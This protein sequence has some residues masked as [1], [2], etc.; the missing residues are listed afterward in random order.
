[1]KLGIVLTIKPYVGGAFT[2]AAFMLEAISRKNDKIHEVVAY[3]SDDLWKKYLTRYDTITGIR[4][5]GEYFEIIDELNHSGCDIIL[6][7]CQLH[8]CRDISIPTITPI[9]DLMHIYERGKGFTELEED[10]CYNIRQLHF[11]DIYSY[12]AGILTDSELGRKHV[13][14]Q[15]G[16]VKEDR[17]YVLPFSVP[18][19]LNEQYGS[20]VAPVVGKYIF[21]PA[22]FWKEK[23][24]EALIKAA[25]LL[26]QK[27]IVVKMVFVGSDKGYLSSLKQLMIDEGVSDE[28]EILG[29]VPDNEMYMLYK[30]A[31]AMVMPSFG[32]PTNL[33]PL[34]AMYVGCPV[35]V[36]NNYAMPE[37]IGDAGLSFDPYDINELANV[38]E[39][40][41]CDDALCRELSTKG[42]KQIK[43]FSIDCFSSNLMNCI[44]DVYHKE[45]LLW[46][47]IKDFVKKC[48]EEEKVYI[49]G[50]GE[51]A[52]YILAILKHYG[53]DVEG[54]IVSGEPTCERFMGKPVVSI[55]SYNY[56]DDSIIVLGMHPN[57]YSAVLGI[58][59][60][61]NISKQHTVELTEAFLSEMRQFFT[62]TRGKACLTGL[63]MLSR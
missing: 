50:A 53:S 8:W 42:K 29:F 39:R 13:L 56:T 36:S 52:W 26:K 61:Y 17:V 37:Q 31:R 58:L 19:Y 6:L 9:H 15:Y 1:M 7:A 49:Y 62:T 45:Q 11:T 25:A 14:D 35:A 40:L 28:F 51:F 27:G 38:L 43:N 18:F 46:T 60:R 54:F 4:L 44:M 22:Q 21:Y 12:S 10:D 63:N 24:H 3:Y 41:W 48:S 2:Y 57:H 47:A 59:D 33:P 30:N 34:E 55:S 16:R 5:N 32:G 23:N 20:T